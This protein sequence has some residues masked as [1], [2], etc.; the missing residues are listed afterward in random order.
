MIYLCLETWQLP[1]VN[2]SSAPKD[3]TIVLFLFFYAIPLL[4]MSF[5]YSIII[6]KLWIRKVPGQRTEAN[7]QQAD[8]SKK[9]VLRMLL[10]VVIVFAMCWLPI[11]I[12][13]F[14]F[15]YG[16]PCGPPIPFIYT[17]FFLGHANSAINPILYVLF[18][19]NYRKGFR[20]ILMCRCG[21]RRV[22]VGATNATIGFDNTYIDKNSIRLTVASPA[23]SQRVN[24]TY[25]DT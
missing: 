10:V 3:F 16:D 24:E 13:Q 6:Y 5:L 25:S 20:D 18:N 8:R 17:G 11:Y 12:T 14:I 15:F 2:N 23:L 22:I 4:A 21:K 9:K 7:Q 19:E 1:P